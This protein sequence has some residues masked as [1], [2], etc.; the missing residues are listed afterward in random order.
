MLR[1]TVRRIRS[2]KL[3]TCALV[4]SAMLIALNVV[5]YM[6]ARSMTHFARGGTR[7]VAPERL[8]FTSKLRVL[9][10]GV[11]VPR[12]VNQQTPADFDLPFTTHLAHSTNG[13]ELE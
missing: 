10:T 11:T 9:L 8:S 12:P 7:T 6:Q 1:R 2:H 4:A 13:H 3:L 5:A